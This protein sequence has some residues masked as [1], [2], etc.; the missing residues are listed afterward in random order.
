ML[1]GSDECAGR[2]EPGPLQG[3]AANPVGP[4]NFGG[5]QPEPDGEPAGAAGRPAPGPVGDHVVVAA[6]VPVGLR[7]PG[8]LPG[9]VEG[10][11]VSLA[12]ADHDVDSGQGAELAQLLGGELGLG[13]A[14]A[15]DHVDLADLARRQGVEH[16]LGD[17]SL[18]QLAW[19][20]GQDPGHVH[21]H[22]ADPDHRYRLGVQDERGRVDVRMPAVP[23]DEVGRRE[24]PRQVL[25]GNAEPPVAH[26][27]GRVYHRV[28]A[29][30]QLG[31]GDVGA[32]VQAAEEADA[33][34][35]EHPAQVV[36]DRLDRLMVGSDAVPD[37]PVRRR[38]PVEHVDPDAPARVDRGGLLDQR[39]SGVEAG[40]DPM[41]ATSSVSIAGDCPLSSARCQVP[42]SG[43]H[44]QVRAVRPAGGA[45]ARGLSAPPPR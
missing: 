2:I 3:Q 8:A 9:R 27:A 42:L 44:C 38:Q 21:C 20:P 45:L 7:Q 37:Q 28:V 18:V 22:V 11:Q 5:P 1:A 10:V 19:V 6:H 30:Q 4:V 25:A 12:V 39:L 33:L 43:V 24:A 13:R 14:A 40:P 31:P 34:V 41:T 23:V 15:A 36:G 17:V 35:L 26:R 16:R 29:G 32:E